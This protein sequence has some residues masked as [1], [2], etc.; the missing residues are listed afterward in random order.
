MRRLAVVALLAIV[1][2]SCSGATPS[3]VASRT[4]TG[5]RNLTISVTGAST[6]AV[7][8]PVTSGAVRVRY[9]GSNTV[10]LITGAGTYSDGVNSGT[11]GVNLAATGMAFNGAITVTPTAAPGFSVAFNFATISIDGDGDFTATSSSGGVTLQFAITTY[12]VP[13]LEANYDTLSALES[14]FCAKAQQSLAGLD[15]L[16]VPLAAIA[17]VNHTTRTAF[18]GSKAIL[19]PLTTQTWGDADEVDSAAGNNLAIT[20]DLSCKTRSADHLATTGVTTGGTDA[21]CSTLNA[22]AL[23]SATALLTPAEA[24]AYAGS[25]HPISLA[26]DKVDASGIE[27]LTPITSVQYGTGPGGST[28]VTAHAL[29]VLWNDPTYAIFPDTIRGVHYCTVKSPSWF[30][31]Y[32]TEGAFNI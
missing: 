17:N 25:G 30:Y 11:F 22:S 31:W 16:Q 9:T 29:L 27:W 13:G 2:T 6:Y 7:A 23:A 4:G 14:D 3:G 18:G 12:N 32:L 5:N 20:G 8:A 1:A 19:S 10:D 15:P 26:P 28:V 24:V 21:Q